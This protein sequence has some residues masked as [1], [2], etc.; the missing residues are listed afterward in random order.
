MLDP[1]FGKLI[2][3]KTPYGCLFCGDRWTGGAT[4]PGKYMKSS[5]RVFYRCGASHSAR[6]AHP[7]TPDIYTMLLKNCGELSEDDPTTQD[8]GRQVES[9]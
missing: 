4:E 8:Q 2:K 7:D 6:L 3:V 5:C 9:V 1:N